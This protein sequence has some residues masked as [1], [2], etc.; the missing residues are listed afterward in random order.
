MSSHWPALRRAIRLS[1]MRKMCRQ[2]FN[3]RRKLIVF[4]SNPRVPSIMRKEGVKELNAIGREMRFVIHN[5]N[6]LDYRIEPAA[7]PQD[8][9]DSIAR[10]GPSVITFSGHVVISPVKGYSVIMENMENGISLV[11]SVMFSDVIADGYESS[12]TSPQ[13]IVL[14]MCFGTYFVDALQGKFP[15]CSIVFWDSEVEDNAA[16]TFAL[17]FFEELA[18]QMQASEPD[19]IKMFD[20][21]CK[22]FFEAGFVSGHPEKL[23]KEE[24]KSHGGKKIGGTAM[25]RRGDYTKSMTTVPVLNSELR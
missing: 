11:P 4:Y 21:A 20:K 9:T 25:Y 1:K 13:C 18:K 8:A 5:L 17:G 10:F 7:T 12:G 22:A 23:T 19:Y 24:K 14:L 15:N 6:P 2:F 3:E 16:S